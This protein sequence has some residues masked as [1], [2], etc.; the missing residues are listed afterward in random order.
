VTLRVLMDKLVWFTTRKSANTPSQALYF[1][2]RLPNN[3]SLSNMGDFDM[4]FNVQLA[5]GSP[6]RQV[7]DFTNVKQ[8]RWRSSSRGVFSQPPP[9]YALSSLPFSRVSVFFFESSL[10]SVVG[11]VLCTPPIWYAWPR[12]LTFTGRS[13][14][15]IGL[16][17]HL[18]AAA[19]RVHRQGVRHPNR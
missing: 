13:S 6:T 5:H 2:F 11:S 9:F 18:S 7:R 1:V 17:H 16:V 14:I 15:V 3:Q 10:S 4:V 12:K 19:L 8:V